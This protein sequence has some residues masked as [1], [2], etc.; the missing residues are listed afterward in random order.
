MTYKEKL[1]KENPIP[2]RIRL[3]YVNRPIDGGISEKTGK[4]LKSYPPEV[5]VLTECITDED[6]DLISN[7]LMLIALSVKKIKEDP[8]LIPLIFKSMKLS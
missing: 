4:P 8:S 5:T 6:W 3:V 7:T 2:Q 1:L